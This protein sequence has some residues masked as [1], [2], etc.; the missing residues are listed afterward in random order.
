MWMKEKPRGRKGHKAIVSERN[1]RR[2]ND[3]LF[4]NRN[5]LTKVL[6]RLTVL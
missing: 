4:P 1:S 3:L 6:K 2:T 5:Q